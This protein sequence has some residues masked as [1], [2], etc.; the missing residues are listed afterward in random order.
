MSLSS[1]T[2]TRGGESP[3]HHAPVRSRPPGGVLGA[4]LAVARL[5]RLRYL[6]LTVPPFAV[7]VVGG[8]A[9]DDVYL[10]A[11]IVAIV[12]LRVIS[13]VGNCVSDRVEDAVDHPQRGPLCERVGYGRL[14]QVVT[15]AAA[16]FLV[17]LVLVMASWRHVDRLALLLW[18]CFLALKL[19]Y[20]YGPRL[21]PRRFSATIL[22][23]G[24]SA[25]MFTVGWINQGIDE[26]QTGLAAVL[27][28]WLAGSTLCGSKDVPNL[29]GDQAIGYQSP[30]LRLLASRRPLARALAIVSLPYV[31]VLALVAGGFRADVLWVLA[32]FPMAVVFT[33]V[34]IGA[35]T[36]GERM[37]V[38]E[39]GYLYW[40]TFMGVALVSLVPTAAT[41]AWM[42]GGLVWFV[43]A[44]LL[45]HPDEAPLGPGGARDAAH[46]FARVATRS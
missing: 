45:V 20:S 42:A 11:G 33:M 12:L 6:S 26:A 15:A 38:R 21:K 14:S 28:L 17:I 31:A 46:A 2:S 41:V 30:Y 4:V 29:E 10:A 27:L 24:L 22:L 13:S 16:L 7:G 36:P 25:G 8:P 1:L 35:R 9:R 37:V 18:L 32:V 19:S 3:R 40:L 5:S 34:L 39:V 43:L 23:G 44:S